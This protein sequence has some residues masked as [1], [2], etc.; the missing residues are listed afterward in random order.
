MGKVF[1]ALNGA[2]NSS[3]ALQPQPRHQEP[4][5]SLAPPLEE[6]NEEI[7]FIEVG[8]RK[9][10]NG[11][12]RV[13]AISPSAPNKPCCP[14]EDQ[15]PAPC[16]AILPEAESTKWEQPAPA[17]EARSDSLGKIKDS[18][19]ELYRQLLDRL[20][21]PRGEAVTR[22][23]LFH[24]ATPAAAELSVSVLLNLA[25]TAAQRYDRTV[26]VVDTA[27][28]QPRLAQALGFPDSPGFCD[29]LA[30]DCHLELAL[31][32]HQPT[33]VLILTTG[34]KTPSHGIR[35]V[36]ET[37]GSVLR[38][39]RQ[40]YDLVLVLGPAWDSGPESQHLATVCDAVYLVLSEA[41]AA[42]SHLDELLEALPQRNTKPTGCILAA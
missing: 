37:V 15:P 33:G 11:S 22:L 12:P 42:T 27:F 35:L 41:D 14:I 20:T 38:Q 25:T 28:Q 1:Q 8:P 5:D 32:R 6:T 7:P 9:S 21:F 4:S 31:Q 30:G 24:A 2:S 13:L 10:I 29:V 23:L 36:A 40:R 17:R 18:N 19:G 3:R 26:I 39:L 16:D 34:K